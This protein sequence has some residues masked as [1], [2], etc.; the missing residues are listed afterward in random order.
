MRN[1]SKEIGGFFNR[2]VKNIAYGLS[3]V[4]NIQSF[5]IE[6]FSVADIAWNKNVRKK[7]HFNCQS[8]SSLASLAS[9]AFYI[10]RKTSALVALCLC[11]WNTCVKLADFIKHTD[12]SYRIASRS[13]SNR[14]LVYADH[15]V[16]IF[17]A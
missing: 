17:Q 8:S 3:L 2:H 16:N 13:S 4:K 6:S 12:V 1:S 14:A 11:F 15:F 7:I 5:L 9:S 10:E